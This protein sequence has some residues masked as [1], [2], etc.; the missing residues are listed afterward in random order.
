[1]SDIYIPIMIWSVPCP[2]Q[3]LHLSQGLGNEAEG[4]K[5]LSSLCLSWDLVTLG[6][7]IV[8]CVSFTH[9]PG[10]QPGAD[11]GTMGL[12]WICIIDIPKLLPT[13]P[14]KV[15]Y[16]GSQARTQ[17]TGLDRLS[18]SSMLGGF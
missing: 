2:G 7:Y 18:V 12:L 4:R 5:T 17:G 16:S 9:F 6:R 11:L 15:V 14:R 10:T 8:Y 3:V 13:H 1:M